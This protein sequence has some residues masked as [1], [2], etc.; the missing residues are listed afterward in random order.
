MK[1]KKI[2]KSLKKSGRDIDI[3]NSI[4]ISLEGFSYWDVVIMDKQG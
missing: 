1:G 2:N 4:E 3:P